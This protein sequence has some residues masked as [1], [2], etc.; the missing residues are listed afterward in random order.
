MSNNIQKQDGYTERSFKYNLHKLIFEKVPPCEASCPYFVEVAETSVTGRAP[1][2][3]Q[4]GKQPKC[5]RDQRYLHGVVEHFI[6]IIAANEMPMQYINELVHLVLPDYILLANINRA[7]ESLGHQLFEQS[8]AGT[9]FHP[10]VAMQG[11]LTEKIQKKEQTILKAVRAD[12]KERRAE[13]LA[14]EKEAQKAFDV[15][16]KAIEEEEDQDIRNKYV[17]T[18]TEP[19]PEVE[20]E[21][22]DIEEE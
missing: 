6:E 4:Q 19:V 8:R 11:Q 22:I 7:V 16:V 5:V 21:V 12:A 9:K 10:A 1:I 2:C 13:E 20:I 14:R 17:V 15:N 3:D 18:A